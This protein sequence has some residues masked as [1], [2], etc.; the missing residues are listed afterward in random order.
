MGGLGDRGVPLRAGKEYLAVGE[1]PTPRPARP[2]PPALPGT[3]TPPRPRPPPG[4]VEIGGGVGCHGVGGPD[5][6]GG[7]GGGGALSMPGYSFPAWGTPRASDCCMHPMRRSGKLLLRGAEL[8]AGAWRS[9]R[10][11]RSSLLIHCARRMHGTLAMRR[12]APQARK[13]AP[14]ASYLSHGPAPGRHGGPACCMAWSSSALQGMEPRA[15][16]VV[17]P[18]APPRGMELRSPRRDVC[19]GMP[20]A[21]GRWVA[22]GGGPPPHPSLPVPPPGVGKGR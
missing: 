21:V 14:C 9:S 22:G 4:G 6:V 17:L 11:A 16:S 5:G 12:G 18:I 13:E 8:H 3:P 10:E 2:A 15:C 20:R 7:W 19:V 1:L